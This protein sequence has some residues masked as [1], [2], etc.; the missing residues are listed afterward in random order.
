VILNKEKKKRVGTKENIYLQH[1]MN[2]KHIYIY[3]YRQGKR[4]LTKETLSKN[5]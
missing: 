4:A 3:I 5:P 1:I 2:K